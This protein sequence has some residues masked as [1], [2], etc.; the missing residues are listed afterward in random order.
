ML[1]AHISTELG[2]FSLDLGF[3]ASPDE[4][5]AVVGPN[6]AGKSTLLRTL[7]GL[8][9]PQ[10]GHVTV[11]D[12]VWEDTEA[13]IRLPA[14]HRNVGYVPQAGLLFPHLTAVENVAF[15]I[16]DDRSAAFDAL[17]RLGLASLAETEPK[18]LSGGQIQLV[19][20][21]RARAA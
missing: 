16:D 20:F 8:Q 13:G 14:E 5:V 11:D 18:A 4:V 15:G 17:D 10:A 2:D 19:A 1:S 12:V 6:G 21:A 3:E 9:P 7:A